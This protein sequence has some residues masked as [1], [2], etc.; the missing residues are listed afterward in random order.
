MAL[1]TVVDKKLIARNISVHMNAQRVN[2]DVKLQVPHIYCIS[3]RPSPT[4]NIVDYSKAH[5]G[6]A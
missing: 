3:S 2:V 5:L 6:M 1:T 4:K